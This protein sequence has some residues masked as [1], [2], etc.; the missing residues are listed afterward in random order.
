MISM[1]VNIIF[2]IVF[3]HLEYLCILVQILTLNSLYFRM[4][5]ALFSDGANVVDS[6]QVQNRR[7]LILELFL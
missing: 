6:R 5:R 2:F 4:E 7:E 1:H 3:V